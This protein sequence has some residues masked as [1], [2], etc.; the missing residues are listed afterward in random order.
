MNNYALYLI[1]IIG[2]YFAGKELFHKVDKKTVSKVDDS[3]KSDPALPKKEDIKEHD[4]W[5]VDVC[6]G[7]CA[8]D[9][10]IIS[11]YS[12]KGLY[13]IDVDISGEYY[14]DGH[15][16]TYNLKNVKTIAIDLPEKD[17]KKYIKSIVVYPA[18]SEGK[19]VVPDPGTSSPT[20]DGPKNGE[21]LV[22]EI[23]KAKK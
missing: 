10:D 22:I 14:K 2:G 5:K 9:S 8:K 19:T 20:G 18:I 17:G 13:F 6:S 7:D 3:I 4:D 16:G 1:A 23:N 15:A 21:E 12:K 11:A